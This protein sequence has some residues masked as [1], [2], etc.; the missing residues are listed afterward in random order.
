M[1]VLRN[2]RVKIIQSTS[3]HVHHHPSMCTNVSNFVE[4][5]AKRLHLF[6][7][8]L[9]RTVISDESARGKKNKRLGKYDITELY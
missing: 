3:G 4:K 5:C 6:F 1:M 8:F 9:S 7:F 2:E